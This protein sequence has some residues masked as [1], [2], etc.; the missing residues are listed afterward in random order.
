MY[1]GPNLSQNQNFYHDPYYQPYHP[2]HHN[3]E[4]HPSHPHLNA[5]QDYSEHYSQEEQRHKGIDDSCYPHPKNMWPPH[6]SQ[7]SQSHSNKQKVSGASN[8]SPSRGDHSDSGG[9]DPKKDQQMKRE[10][11]KLRL[12]DLDSPTNKVNVQPKL[13]LNL[14]LDSPVNENDRDYECYDF[15][16]KTPHDHMNSNNAG[17]YTPQNSNF[18]NRLQQKLPSNQQ[19]AENKVYFT[20]KQATVGRNASNKQTGFTALYQR[21]VNSDATL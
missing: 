21:I 20:P 5:Y 18:T 3:H 4:T 13:K 12:P 11:L 16:V 15:K 17:F 9:N 14:D 2:T 10:T 19:P 8:S 1:M 6:I 7:G